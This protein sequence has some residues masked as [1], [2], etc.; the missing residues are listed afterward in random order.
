MDQ[1]RKLVQLG[2]KSQ[3]PGE[4]ETSQLKIHEILSCEAK[5]AKNV[6]NVNNQRAAPVDNQERESSLSLSLRITLW[7]TK[8]SPRK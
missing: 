7:Y 3:L 2:I 5:K 4:K 6:G 1:S 8:V